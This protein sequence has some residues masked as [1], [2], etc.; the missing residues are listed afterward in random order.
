MKTILKT[1]QESS[2]RNVY[3]KIF[4]AAIIF[5]ICIFTVNAQNF[6]HSI[7]G[8]VAETNQAFA[9]ETGHSDMY[10]EISI[11]PKANNLTLF[12]GYLETEETM[13]LED[14]MTNKDNFYMA[15][16]I[17]TEVDDAMELENWMTNEKLF[18]GTTFSLITE[19]D[20]K[21]ELENWMTDENRFNVTTKTVKRN[22][23]ITDTYRFQDSEDKILELEP[24]M[25]NS[26]LFVR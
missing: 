13:K 11:Q 14:W 5:G 19:T 9:M 10:Y 6:I 2:F 4:A 23:I 22:S 21:L 12:A 1:K 17:E 15:L 18:D 24:W 16:T 3:S 25:V 20:E 8:Y 26:R 7:S